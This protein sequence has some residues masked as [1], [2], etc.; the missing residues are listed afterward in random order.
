MASQY[1]LQ[2]GTMMEW[3]TVDRTDRQVCPNCRYVHYQNLKTGAGA[4]IESAGKLL[5]LQRIQA[6][7]L[8][9]WNLPAGYSELDEPPRQTAVR[10]V[11]EETGLEVRAESLVEIYHFS[12][13]SRGN[14]LLV[15]YRCRVVGGALR[16]SEEAWQL[17]YFE[18]AGVPE[19]LAGGGHNQAI[20]DWMNR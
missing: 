18:P 17:Q 15:V 13:D 2:C 6:P 8:H 4:I 1:C 14:G 11:A 7:F 10:E 16:G 12:D 5:L 20:R 9:C 3:R 19:A